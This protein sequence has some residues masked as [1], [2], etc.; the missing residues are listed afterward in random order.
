MSNSF[1]SDMHSVSPRNDIGHDKKVQ[2]D[3]QTLQCHIEHH[4]PVKTPLCRETS[5][6]HVVARE[7]CGKRF[8]WDKS[9]T[10]MV[11]NHK[12]ECSI[13]KRIFNRKDSQVEKKYG[14]VIGALLKKNVWLHTENENTQWLIHPL[15]ANTVTLLHHLD[16]C[17]LYRHHYVVGHCLD[18]VWDL[19]RI[20]SNGIIHI[21]SGTLC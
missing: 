18:N 3:I 15:I 5:P 12:Y 13:C 19:C 11:N 8:T 1:P 16:I 9:L 10:C 4:T 7:G 17:L 14:S 6:G 20:E 2:H 21:S